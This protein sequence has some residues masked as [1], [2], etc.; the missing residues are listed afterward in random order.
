M[1][2]YNTTTVGMATIYIPRAGYSFAD[3]NT[4]VRAVCGQ[5]GMWSGIPSDSSLGTFIMMQYNYL[6]FCGT[7]LGHLKLKRNYQGIG[8][9]F[10]VSVN[11][12]TNWIFKVLSITYNIHVVLGVTYLLFSN[13]DVWTLSFNAHQKSTKNTIMLISFIYI[14]NITY[15]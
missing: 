13:K 5:D 1:K 14:V 15:I 9:R 2:L 6:V 12:L 11:S 3:G 7:L 8:A 10:Y 4:S